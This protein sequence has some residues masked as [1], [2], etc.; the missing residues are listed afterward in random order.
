[1]TKSEFDAD[2][3]NAVIP[4]F[5]MLANSHPGLVN[6]NN[7][8]C[9]QRRPWTDRS[10]PVTGSFSECQRLTFSASNHIAKGEEIFAEYGDNWFRHRSSIFGNLPLS[11]DFVE[12]DRLLRKWVKVINEENQTGLSEELWTTSAKILEDHMHFERLYNALPK[13]GKE[14]TEWLRLYPKQT[15]ARA[16]VPD[17]IRSEEWLNENG[18]CL[19]NIKVKDAGEKG[20]GA[21]ASR[22]IPKGSL[23]APAPVIH[24]SREDMKLIWEEGYDIRRP[25]AKR[26]L[27]QGDQLL[28]NYCYGNPM[29]SLLFFPYSPAVNLINHGKPANV[30][31]RWSNH[32]KSEML[33]WSTKKVLEQNTKA[34]LMMEIYALKNIQPGT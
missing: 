16:T 5:G 21:F 13:T 1:M 6:A 12:A 9:Q 22:F 18:M 2:Q 20:K 31:I 8:G 17:V 7:D 27:W 15:T 26:Q 28:L 30:A 32:S 11:Q 23:V 14:A 24:L 33:E 34:G 10:N 3:V 19:D 25:S 29:T 4:G